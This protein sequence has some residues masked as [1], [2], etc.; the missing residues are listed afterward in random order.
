LRTLSEVKNI[1]GEAGNFKV[2]LI[3]HPRYINETLCIGCGACAQKCPKKIVDTYNAGLSQRRSAYV[4][5]AQAVPLKY[6]IDGD[7]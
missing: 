5:Y 6:C 3:E 7:S 2:E 1:R 4:E